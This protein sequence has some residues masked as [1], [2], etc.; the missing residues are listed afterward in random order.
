MSSQS[1]GEGKI[2]VVRRERDMVLAL[3]L[4]S[5]VIIVTFIVSIASA[6]YNNVE[7]ARKILGD[8]STY[9]AFAAFLI[10]LYLVAWAYGRRKQEIY[11]MWYY[12]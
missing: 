1:E 4:V 11:G 3:Y 5:I 9:L 7:Y 10:V 8:L 6:E 12:S 2:Q